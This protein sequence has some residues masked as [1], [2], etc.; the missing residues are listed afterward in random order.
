MVLQPEGKPIEVAL[1]NFVQV[2]RLILHVEFICVN[3]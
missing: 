3:E 2:L 1:V